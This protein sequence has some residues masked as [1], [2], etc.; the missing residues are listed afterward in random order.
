MSDL[1][2]LAVRIT[3]S[4]IAITN[5]ELEKLGVTAGKTERQTEALGKTSL[6]TSRSFGVFSSAIGALGLGLAARAV[7]D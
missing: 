6:S 3:S 1:A 2:T 5:T 4:G 7:V